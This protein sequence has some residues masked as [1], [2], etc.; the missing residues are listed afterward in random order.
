MTNFVPIGVIR[1]RIPEMYPKYL[2]GK[3]WPYH[4][5]CFLNSFLYDPSC[6]AWLFKRFIFEI[7]A[8]YSFKITFILV[9]QVISLK[10][11]GGVI[12]KIYCLISWSPI[13]THLILLSASVK[14]AGTSAAEYITRWEWTPLGKFPYKGKRF[15]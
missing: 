9:K 5:S 2:N 6:K 11:N 4:L 15:R 10:E 13:W 14:M 8:S 12:S 3:F 1:D 7:E